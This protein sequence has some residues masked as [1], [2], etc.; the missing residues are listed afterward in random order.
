MAAA[1]YTA[2]S[3][4][5]GANT[6]TAAVLAPL[7]TQARIYFAT[8]ADVEGEKAATAATA[9]LGIRGADG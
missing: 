4:P 1:G 2:V 8:D 5:N 9:I 6:A 3:L 7:Q